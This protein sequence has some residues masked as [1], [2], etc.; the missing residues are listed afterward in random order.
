MKI[1]GQNCQQAENDHDYFDRNIRDL[2]TIEQ[3]DGQ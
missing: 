2:K 1:Y 3:D